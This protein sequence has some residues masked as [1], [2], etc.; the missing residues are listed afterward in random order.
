MPNSKYGDRIS[1]Q[2][3]RKEDEEFIEM[4]QQQ[5]GDDGLYS[6]EDDDT[7][8]FRTP[9]C[10]IPVPAHCLGA[11]KKSLNR[12]F[13]RYLEKKQ[14]QFEDGLS[15]STEDDDNDGFRTPTSLKH[16][17]QVPT[18]SCLPAPKKSSRRK[19]EGSIMLKL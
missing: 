8:G 14:L 1:D 11:P 16:R 7:D 4:K 6:I 10:K 17:I 9:T 5:F 18:S 19:I 2:E 13:E 15:S 12:K 3:L